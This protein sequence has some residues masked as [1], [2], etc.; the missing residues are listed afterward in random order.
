[1]SRTYKTAATRR[2]HARAV[3]SVRTETR[4]P[5][6][7]PAGVP[8]ADRPVRFDTKIAVLLADDLAP[9]Q[10]LNVTAFLASGIAAARP[11]LIGEPYADA[12]ATGYLALFRQPVMI[13]AGDRATVRAAHRRAL[14]RGLSVAVYTQ[15][16]FST[17]HDAA[18]RAAV[19]AVR[20]DELDL[21]GIA[22][23][24]GRSAV[25]KAMKGARKHP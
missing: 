16:M 7:E 17:A 12:D 1:M 10:E 4:G 24:G 11:E 9:W 18:N 5:V 3:E 2:R 23:H 6:P 13:F 25:D 8:A 15:E 20:R 22:V 19:A 21:V 14:D